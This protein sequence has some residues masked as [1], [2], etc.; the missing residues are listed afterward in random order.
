MAKLER[1]AAR[2]ATES[3]LGAWGNTVSLKK[4]QGFEHCGGKRVA[5]SR[6][7]I[8]ALPKQTDRFLKCVGPVVQVHTYVADWAFILLV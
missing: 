6:A 2:H 1:K 8:S 3:D 7:N 5:C 4:G